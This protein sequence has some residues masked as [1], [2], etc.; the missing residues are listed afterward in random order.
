MRGGKFEVKSGFDGES[1][2]SLSM[3]V[4]L[5]PFTFVALWMF[6]GSIRESGWFRK[7]GFVWVL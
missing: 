7:H 4:G 6:P 5:S 2:V 3:H 1:D